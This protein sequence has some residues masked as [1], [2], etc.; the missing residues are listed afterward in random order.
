MIIRKKATR[1]WAVI[2]VCS[3]GLYTT[4]CDSGEW[5]GKEEAPANIEL[6]FTASIS[7]SPSTRTAPMAGTAFPDGTHTFGMFITDE[8][9]SNP[10]VT[11]SGDNM[12]SILT[13]TG[14]SDTWTHTD[15]DDASLFLKAKNGES[16][17]LS[18]Y[19]PWVSGATATAVPFSLSGDMSTDIDL[20][21]LSSPTGVQQ[22]TDAGSIELKFSHA[23]CWVTIKLSKLKNAP[24]SVK[25]VSIGNSYNSLKNR[26]INAGKINPKTGDV[27]PR[28]GTPGS[29]ENIFDNPVSVPE[30]GG[31]TAP[32]EFNFLVPSFMHEDILD[33]DVVIRVTDSNDKVLSFPLSKIHLNSSAN[34]DKY[35]F[36]KGKHNTYNIVYN[37]AEMILSLEGW[38]ETSIESSTLGEGTVGVVP[39]ELSWTGSHNTVAAGEGTKLK[40]L[41]KGNHINHTYL[42]EVA[43]NNNGAYVR[44][45]TG[46]GTLFGIWKPFMF[47]ELFYLNLKVARGLAAGG[48]PVPWKDKETGA[49]LAKQACLE[50]REGG[51]K[52]WRLPRVSEFF[53]MVYNTPDDFFYEKSKEFWSATEYDSDRSFR[54]LECW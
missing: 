35:G 39:F 38:Q 33:T 48:S 15:K 36:E 27:V 21:Y 47:A 44:L 11:G 23:Y 12:K 16:I 40:K 30:D 54:R 10:L 8:G 1:I 5:P 34:P 26:I 49:L 24:L 31:A 25:S 51:Y 18:G 41:K 53:M 14:N 32:I 42:G 52:D 7:D 46:T 43:E 19:Y 22:V 45:T 3:L 6:R 13:R 20:L 2:S 37:N 29:L 17:N 50:F 4:A 28:S 9:G